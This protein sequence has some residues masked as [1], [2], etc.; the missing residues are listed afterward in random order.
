MWNMIPMSMI[1]PNKPWKTTKAIAAVFVWKKPA[2]AVFDQM[3]SP[4][5]DSKVSSIEKMKMTPF[6]TYDSNGISS[7][8]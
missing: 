2:S 3:R 7:A 5:I 1:T 8:L 4:E 6:P